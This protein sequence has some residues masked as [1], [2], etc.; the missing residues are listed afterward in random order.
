MTVA[1]LIDYLGQF[2]SN[3]TVVLHDDDFEG[4]GDYISL[5]NLDYMIEDDSE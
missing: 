1:E 3:M 4:D 5:S 2:P